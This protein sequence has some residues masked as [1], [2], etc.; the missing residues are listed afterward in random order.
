M[1]DLIHISGASQRVQ[2]NGRGEWVAWYEC[3]KCKDEFAASYEFCKTEKEARDESETKFDKQA[4]KFCYRCGY[5]LT[6]REVAPESE[7]INNLNDEINKLQQEVRASSYSI[8]QY[9]ENVHRL[10][11]AHKT[12]VKVLKKRNEKLF[13]LNELALEL[14]ESRNDYKFCYEECFKKVCSLCVNKK[15]CNEFSCG[16]EF[17]DFKL[18]PKLKLRRKSK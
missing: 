2:Q 12:L 4:R 9:K 7:C 10:T 17:N 8:K 13:E 11:D 14:K 15:S 18:N 5:K 16:L 6:D 1:N 3:H